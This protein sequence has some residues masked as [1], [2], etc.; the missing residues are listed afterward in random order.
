MKRPVCYSAPAQ[1]IHAL[2]REVGTAGVG[3]KREVGTA[4]VGLK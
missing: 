3:L 2:K 4:G 1:C